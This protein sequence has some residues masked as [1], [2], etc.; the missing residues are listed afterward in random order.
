MNVCPA[1]HS[2]DSVE[3]FFW[4]RPK[5]V[6][7]RQHIDASLVM[8]EIDRELLNWRDFEWPS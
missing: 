8:A 3:G 4:F 7:V 1:F 5:S 6:T 2:S